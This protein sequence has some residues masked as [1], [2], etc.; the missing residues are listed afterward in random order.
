LPRSVKDRSSGPGGKFELC[1]SACRI[2]WVP[3]NLVASVT[4]WSNYNRYSMVDVG[5]R[6]R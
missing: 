3:V 4:T 5:G 6:M 1:S 2:F